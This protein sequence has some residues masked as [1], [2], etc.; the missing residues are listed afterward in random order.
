MQQRP[1]VMRGIDVPVKTGD[2]QEVR[3]TPETFKAYVA[4][5]SNWAK[6]GTPSETLAGAPVEVATS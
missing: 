4:Q 5:N 1:G 6:A 2:V 3:S